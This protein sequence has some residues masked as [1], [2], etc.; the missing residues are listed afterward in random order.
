MRVKRSGQHPGILA[1]AEVGFTPKNRKLRKICGHRRLPF[2][3]RDLSEWP[4]LGFVRFDSVDDR[5]E[6]SLFG[7]AFNAAHQVIGALDQ[8]GVHGIGDA[9]EMGNRIAAGTHLP[10]RLFDACCSVA[11]GCCPVPPFLLPLAMLGRFEA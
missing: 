5:G 10:M 6:L 11:H 7:R 8:Q 3:T 2:P 4:S 9:G 1:C